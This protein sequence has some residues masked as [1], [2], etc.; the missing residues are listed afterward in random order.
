MNERRLIIILILFSAVLFFTGLGRMA[1]TDPDEVFYAETAK[2]MQNRQSFLTPYIFGKPQFEKPPLYYWLVMSGFRVFGINEFSARFASAAFGIFGVIGIYFLGKILI[3]KRT[4]FLAGIVLA[5]SVKYAVLSRACVTDIVLC[6][7]MLYAFLFFFR[8]QYM[9]STVSLGLA[10]LTKGPVAVFLPVVIIGLYLIFT[11]GLGR[12]KEIPFIRGTLL[13]L[14]VSL[15]WYFLMYR[16]HG[17]E[18]IDV[19]FGF[20]NVIRF[21]E[22]EHK[23]GDVFYYYFPILLGGFFP[24]SIFLPLGVWQVFREKEEKIRKAGLFS[25]IWILVIFIF[26]SAARTRLPTYIFPLYPAAALLMGRVLDVFAENALSRRQKK[27]A[28]ILTILLVIT[29]IGSAIGLYVVAK[30][31]YPTTLSV[32]PRLILSELGKYESSKHISKKLLALAKPGEEIGAETQ[33]RRGVAFYTQRENIPDIHR[34]HIMTDFFSK[35]DR[36]WGVIK[37]KNYDQLYD[38]LEKPFD[39]ATYVVY[40]FGKKVIVTNKMP[41]GVKFLKMKDKN[42]AR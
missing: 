19:F 33:Y 24:W 2:E 35:K 8:K 42:A 26:F 30:K 21:L 17:K 4:G 23:I 14:A 15:P 3:N 39:K 25:I 27:T 34:H 31:K 20:H 38:D 7:F 37:E 11:K 13:F 5:T 32:S 41:P 6:V 22:P 10:V 29:I 18:F 9:L 40:K 16:V 12:L 36:V 1:L 28:N